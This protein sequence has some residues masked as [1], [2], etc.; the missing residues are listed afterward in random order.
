M[1]PIIVKSRKTKIVPT[2]TPESVRPHSQTGSK[3]LTDTTRN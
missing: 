2:V 3:K 1:Q